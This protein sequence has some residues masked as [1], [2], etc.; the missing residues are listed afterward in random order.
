MD[1]HIVEV[2]AIWSSRLLIQRA[3]F[4]ACASQSIIFQAL[5]LESKW[6]AAVLSGRAELPVEEDMTADVE[7]EY[8]RMENAGK[9]K[10]H[11]HTLWPRWVSVRPLNRLSLS[12]LSVNLDRLGC[13]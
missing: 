6:V 1:M 2:E 3:R 4:L 13:G 5:E 12:L 11:T 9:P 7:E 10:R 8:Q